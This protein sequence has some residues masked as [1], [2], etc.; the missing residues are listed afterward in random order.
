LKTATSPVE[1]AAANAGP[2]PPELTVEMGL[3]REPCG[4]ISKDWMAP[5]LL[6]C[7]VAAL[8]RVQ[9]RWEV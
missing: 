7:L 5:G 1:R 9:N 6:V 4:V 2:M 3:E 8:G